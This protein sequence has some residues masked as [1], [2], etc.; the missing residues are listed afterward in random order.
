M[1]EPQAETPQSHLIAGDGSQAPTPQ[2]TDGID[3]EGSG[4]HEGDNPFDIELTQEEKRRVS[5]RRKKNENRRESLVEDPNQVNIHQFYPELEHQFMKSN[6]KFNDDQGQ[7]VEKA[8]KEFVDEDSS[9]KS[10]QVE[11]SNNGT[12][13]SMQLV[14]KE[15]SET[16]TPVWTKEDENNSSDPQKSQRTAG[17]AGSEGVFGTE[18]GEDALEQAKA[19]QKQGTVEPKRGSLFQPESW[20][21]DKP[22]Q[23]S[24]SEIMAETAEKHLNKAMLLKEA[25][26]YE[27]VIL[28]IN[29]ALQIK[30]EDVRYYIERGEI[31]RAHV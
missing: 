9:L 29:K 28:W 19:R 24:M 11:D 27:G 18:V 6:S 22:Y 13:A 23:P 21:M 1:S 16:A 25:G 4:D 3:R 15:E 7:Q 17:T 26:D 5:E 30:G 31:G 20:G 2:S 8:I 14:P 10:Q 12:E